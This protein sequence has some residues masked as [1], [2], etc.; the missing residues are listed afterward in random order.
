M[1][2]K[3]NI[4]K[5]TSRISSSNVIKDIR[6][7][8][9]VTARVV[10]KINNQ[11]AVL[12]IAGRRI[13]AEFLKGI[14]ESSRIN[15]ILEKKSSDV[16]FFKLIDSANNSNIEKILEYSIFDKKDI[17]KMGVFELARSIKEGLSKVF[18]L[19]NLLMK[20]IGDTTH[21]SMGSAILF[22][23]LLKLKIKEENLILL[24][25]LL[26]SGRGIKVDQLFS[27]L[28]ILGF[29][30]NHLSELKKILKDEN[31]IRERIDDIL[32]RISEFS[33]KEEK[34]ELI[35]ALIDILLSNSNKIEDVHSGD[36]PYYD[37]S[38]FTSILYIFNN[39]AIIFSIDFSY[40]GVMD[41]LIKENK[42][43]LSIAIFCE[44]DSTI[45][46][47]RKRI[48]SFHSTVKNS[49]NR[50]VH[51]YLHNSQ[52]AVEKIIEIN[53]LG[54]SNSIMDIRI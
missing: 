27:L 50:D 16:F 7:G 47:F 14:P 17:H 15:L 18:D 22:N 4:I 45:D 21:Q 24:S 32:E 2:E 37:G 1:I 52:K 9:K 38:K 5:V 6:M 12:E 28:Q 43:D 31:I 29:G 34:R 35:K 41:I 19:N 48:D 30:N 26:C 25:L 13:K 42:S 39:N 36:I 11:F 23:T 10:E 33:N 40:L 8:S 46:E 51:I 3:S 44:K 20:I 49:L 54:I 53:S